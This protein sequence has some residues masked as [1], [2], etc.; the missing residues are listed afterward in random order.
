MKPTFFKLTT[1]AILVAGLAG[2]SGEKSA[3]EHL[4]SG[5]QAIAEQ[6]IEQAII[7]YKNAVRLAPK[8]ATMRLSLGKA[9]VQLGDY[10]G[11]E[12]ELKKSIELGITDNQALVSL[13][14]AKAKLEKLS[15]L[16]E[17]LENTDMLKD[18]EY[19]QVLIDSAIAFLSERQ[20]EKAQDLIE[21][22]SAIDADSNY[23][24]LGQA[25]I[26]YANGDFKEASKLLSDNPLL[27]DGGSEATLLNGHLLF[28]L[29]QFEEAIG[30]YKKYRAAHPAAHYVRFFETNS[31][32]RAGL[33]DVAEREV[34]EL[35]KLTKGAPLANQY[36][37]QVEYNKGNYQEA[38]NYADLAA[39]ANNQFLTARLVAGVSAYMLENNESAYSYLN[40][41]EKFLSS[42]HPVKKL[43]AVLKVRMG[44][45]DDAVQS[46]DSLSDLTENDASFLADAS[47]QML[48]AGDFESAREMIEEAVNLNPN[49]ANLV[50]KK[51]FILLSQNDLTGIES[52]E[53]ALS[54]DPNLT[55]VE[56][57]LALQYLKSGEDKK[58][59]EIAD[60]WLKEDNNSASGHLLQGMIYVRSNQFANAQQ[61][62]ESA[63]KAEPNNTG[64]LFGLAGVYEQNGLMPK[65]IT[66]YKQIVKL[67]PSHKEAI[68]ALIKAG[69]KSG[70]INQSIENIETAFAEHPQSVYLAIGLAQHYR[71]TKQPEKAVKVLEDLEQK[72]NLPLSYWLTLGDG[73]MEAKLINKAQST[74]EKA[75][76]AT[77]DNYLFYT[78]LIS[79]YEINE[80]FQAALAMAE[81]AYSLYPENTRL[82]ALLAYFKFRNKDYD[83]ALKEIDKVTAKNV[84]H[85]FVD[86]TA[87]Y[88]AI[89]QK[90]YNDAIE[91]FSASFEM[92]PDA[93]NA[94]N[95]ARALK[96]NGQQAEA[97]QTLEKFL[98]NTPNVGIRFFLSSL[99]LPKDKAKAVKQYELIL[100][101]HPENIVVRNNL[102]WMMLEDNNLD[103]ALEH[104][105]FAHNLQSDFLPVLETYGVILH[106]MGNKTKAKTVLQ[107]A[108][109]KGSTDA[110][111]L[112]V[113]SDILVDEN[114][115]QSA[116]N[117]LVK[118]KTQDEDVLSLL[119]AVKKR[120]N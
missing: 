90:R 110:R 109:S 43:I 30:V 41:L 83:G 6:N 22:A 60:K 100:E 67:N 3:E 25:Y 68:A 69:I 115:I 102:A 58:A 54:L 49:D 18:E 106:R 9:Y 27:G 51:G 86:T 66:N 97:E 28:A 95:L 56:Y 57:S 36:K 47:A 114:D 62:F 10:L 31:A 19:I 24:K 50:A 26:E 89:V 5:Q 53:A 1:V 12:K 63:L 37:A 32:L 91:S 48:K 85:P 11:A 76:K 78:R 82:E 77:S 61:S 87:G 14:K 72:E 17:L 34:D 52:L 84:K 45:V 98:E 8:D 29:E 71:L 59:Q 108:V 107:Q 4:V 46:F 92:Q 79:V 113:L 70:D 74:Y 44:Y 64:A 65:A 103:K 73:Y 42:S 117:L 120:I 81:K 38:Y 21:Q 33:F 101:A 13:I 16:D 94:L 104:I 23:S 40:P 111:V 116:K 119:R 80:E 2:C 75:I 105:E 88:L 55:E 35:L 39:K 7:H 118:V 93:K 99:Y 96:Y 112:V 20:I 15:E